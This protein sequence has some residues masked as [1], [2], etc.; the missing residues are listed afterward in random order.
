MEIDRWESGAWEGHVPTVPLNPFL[1]EP[2]R[3]YFVR[4]AK[5]VTWIMQ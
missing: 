3:G 1:I 5:S 2:G 4:V